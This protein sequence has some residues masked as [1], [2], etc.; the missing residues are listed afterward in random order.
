M[1]QKGN[2]AAMRDVSI[3]LKREEFVGRME[4]R[5]RRSDVALTDAPIM[6]R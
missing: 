5:W 4:Q 3:M 1:A 2:D 6:P